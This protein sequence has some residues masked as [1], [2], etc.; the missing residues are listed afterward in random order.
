MAEGDIP[1]QE[2][3]V[4]ECEAWFLETRDTLS[5]SLSRETNEESGTT[6]KP[7][8]KSGADWNSIQTGFISARISH[9][10]S[11]EPDTTGEDRSSNPSSGGISS[12][13]ETSK[14]VSNISP[15]AF[16]GMKR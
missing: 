14:S 13:G 2:S 12:P 10:Q 11:M 6:A 3:L 9:V 7:A 5:K 4:I 16:F 1:L 8:E 15:I